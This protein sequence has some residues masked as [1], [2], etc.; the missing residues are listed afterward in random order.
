MGVSEICLCLFVGVSEV[1]LCLFV[2]VS[3][4]CLCLFGGVSKI[5]L[6]LFVGVCGCIFVFLPLNFHFPHPTYFLSFF[7][8]FIPYSNLSNF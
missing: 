3:K 7:H 4:I 2:G 5:C 1:C 6:C 8:L